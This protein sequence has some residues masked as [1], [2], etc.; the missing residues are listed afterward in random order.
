MATVNQLKTTQIF[1]G[2]EE[3]YLKKLVEMSQEEVHHKGHVIFREGDEAKSLYI[4]RE[5][6]VALDMKIET[7]VG[8]G[9]HQATVDLAKK[10]A[11][12]GWSA[13]V[14]PYI[15]T[16]SATCMEPV[17]VVLF[18]AKQLRK[19]LDSDAGL[20]YQVMKKMV[21]L[22]S[23]RLAHTRNMLLNERGLYNVPSWRY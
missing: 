19:L 12:F 3:S 16:L 18:D 2:I 23:S 13:L 10:G 8:Q 5:G 4:L 11:A 20:G 15:Y 21:G 17:S 1:K 22:V 9:V 7:G 6:Q 14:E